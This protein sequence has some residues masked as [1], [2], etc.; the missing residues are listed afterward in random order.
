MIDAVWIPFCVRAVNP[1]N[2][3]KLWPFGPV[4]IA[5]N[6][7]PGLNSIP[8]LVS[9]DCQRPA[10]LCWSWNLTKE[11]SGHL[12]LS[13]TKEI[14]LQLW[15]WVNVLELKLGEFQFNNPIS[16]INMQVDKINLNVI[17]KRMLEEFV[18]NTSFIG[19]TISRWSF[20]N[21]NG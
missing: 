13:W 12:S 9:V 8:W 20:H 10:A 5:F 3:G 14:I 15:D 6:C 4:W 2:C 1:E 17:T 19:G 11:A 16:W 7:R 18:R 21:N